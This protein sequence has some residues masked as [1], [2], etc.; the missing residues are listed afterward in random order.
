[1]NSYMARLSYILSVAIYQVF[2]SRPNV[3]TV[4]LEYIYLSQS[5]DNTKHLGGLSDPTI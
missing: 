3:L 4:I 5:D 2:S 1:M